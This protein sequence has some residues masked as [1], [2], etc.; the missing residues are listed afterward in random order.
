MV[1][2]GFPGGTGGKENTC[3]CRICKRGGFNPCVRKIHGV[4]NGNPLQYSS[5]ENSMDRGAWQATAQ[6]GYSC[7]HRLPL[8]SKQI[9]WDS[10]LENRKL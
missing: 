4:G 1:I 2:M 6:G 10:T 9:A 8:R 5:L 3:Q 7:A